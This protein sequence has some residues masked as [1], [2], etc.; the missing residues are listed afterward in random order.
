MSSQAAKV[1]TNL[2]FSKI[3]FAILVVAIVF[4]I[5]IM[6]SLLLEKDVVEV[7][8]S[9][10]RGTFG[11]KYGITAVIQR[12]TPLLLTGV[13]IALA[14]RARI[15]NIGAEGQ[16]YIGAL[17]T[18]WAG[19][20]FNLPQ[21]IFIPFLFVLSFLGGG[22][23]ALVAAFLKAKF[24]TNEFL[25]T[26]M[27]NFLAIFLTSWA[28]LG[29][30]KGS[31]LGLAQT[32]DISPNAILPL[33]GD[34]RIHFG[35]IIA[36]G[37]C[38]GVY[39]FLEKTK[40][41]LEIRIVGSNPIAGRTAGVNTFRGIMMAMLISGGLSGIA[42]MIE[43]TGIH[44]RLLNGISPGYGYTGIVIALIPNLNPLGV[45]PT[46]LLFGTTFAGTESV[47]RIAGLPIGMV[48]MIQGIVL[49]AVISLRSGRIHFW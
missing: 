16:L 20:T 41:G 37:A 35:I 39:Y 48:Y 12:T 19:L 24:G 32:D 17:L 3:S 4:A 43:V 1:K 47:H 31:V 33:I 40:K 38:I 44:H 34:T 23:W 13:G 46:A 5:L 36:I 22:A 29:P 7:L 45:I 2:K 18:T 25:V 21:P 14:F 9:F 42:G 10:Y 49:L 28:I 30:L 15:I 11:T 8:G 27:M 26:F 6:A